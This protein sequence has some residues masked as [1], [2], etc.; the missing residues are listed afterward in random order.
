M[1]HHY[2]KMGVLWPMEKRIFQ[3]PFSRS[4]Y[5][6]AYF[7]AVKRVG[8]ILSD[9]YAPLMLERA[10]CYSK[11]NLKKDRSNKVWF[12]WLQGL[13][14]APQIIQICYKSLCRHL[15]D[16]DIVV[17]DGNNWKDYIEL[18][19]YIIDKWERRQIPPALF[20]DL[21]R[22]QLLIRY[23]GTWIDSTVLCT[24]FTEQNSE[25]SRAYLDADLFMFQYTRPG[26]LQWGG[27]KK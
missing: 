4:S 19:D 23:G 26:S 25:Y 6:E 11:P 1:V 22:L 5:K 10:V 3:N 13:S 9:K 27:E 2:A 24:G 14:V 20:A 12:C 18:P 21:L 15:S 16:R 17:V 8:P 7:D